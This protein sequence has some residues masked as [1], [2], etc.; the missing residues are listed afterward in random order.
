LQ[1]SGGRLIVSHYSKAI[2]HGEKF[3][4]EIPDSGQTIITGIKYCIY[5][6]KGGKAKYYSRDTEFN[7]SYE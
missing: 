4:Y 5:R 1:Y 7:F 2:I 3:D 6:V